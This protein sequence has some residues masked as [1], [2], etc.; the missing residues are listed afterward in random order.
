MS[1]KHIPLLIEHML[2]KS[3]DVE[4]GG[5]MIEKN[6]KICFGGRYFS[7][8]VGHIFNWCAIPL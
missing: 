1:I 5:K 2:E 4:D 6:Y 3:N 7:N 8:I